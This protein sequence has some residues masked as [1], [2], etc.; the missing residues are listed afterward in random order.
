MHGAW[1]NM[2][3][4]EMMY[5]IFFDDRNGRRNISQPVELKQW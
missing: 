3:H 1:M 2:A 5:W 4:L